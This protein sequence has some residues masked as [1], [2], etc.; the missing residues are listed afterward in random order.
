MQIMYYFLGSL[1]LVSLT[2][3]T[4]SLIETHNQNLKIL[5]CN[6]YWSYRWKIIYIRIILTDS[7]LKIWIDLHCSWFTWLIS[8]GVVQEK[9]KKWDVFNLVSNKCFKI[10]IFF[11]L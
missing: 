6:D 8:F 4:A 3:K 2:E 5:V 11:S 1:Y 7:K 10:I 9:L